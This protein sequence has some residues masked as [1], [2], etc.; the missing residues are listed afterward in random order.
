MS[1][2]S[3]INTIVDIEGKDVD[4]EEEIIKDFDNKRCEQLIGKVCHL[5]LMSFI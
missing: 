1:H 2:G 4:V 5:F 3:D